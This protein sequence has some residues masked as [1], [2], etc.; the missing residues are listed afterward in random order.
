[1]EF[2]TQSLVLV[3]VVSTMFNVGLL[4]SAREIVLALDDRPWL[5]RALLANLVLLPALALAVAWLLQLD[6]VLRAGM[7]ILAT[8]PGGPALIKLASLARGDAA[9]AVG[10]LVVLLLAGVVSQ[11]LLLPLL[12]DEVSV[13]PGAIILTLVCTVL[14]P[15]LLGLQVRQRLARLAS[16]LQLPMQR[17]STL[18]ML[19][20]LILLPILHWQE[21]REIS[22]GGA[23]AAALLFIALATIGGWLLGGPQSAARRMLSLSCAQPN[24]AAAIIIAGQNFSDPRVALMLLVIMI[25][26]LPIV[27]SLSL[28]YARQEREGGSLR[29]ASQ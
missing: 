24:M 15:L 28:L 6:A 1:M 22:R 26:S 20:I 18:S 29:P 5:A 21:L 25:S 12:L 3:F 23:F 19:S 16:S 10:L 4:L 14:V 17:L 2:V 7:L 8:A 11:P 27:I 13:G 9:L